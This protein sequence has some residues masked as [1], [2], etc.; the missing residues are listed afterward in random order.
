[1]VS[2]ALLDTGT[3]SSYLSAALVEQV[4]KCPMH[5]DHKQIK[6]MLCSTFQKVQSYTVK[7]AS[8]DGTF[9]MTTKISKVD[10]GVILTVPNP[11]Y[12]E[13]ISKNHHLEVRVMDNN[14]TKVNYPFT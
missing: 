13:L 1:M 4:N 11:N 2:N 9:E 14:D 5:V 3:G 10:K 7:V 6:M 8:V 12:E